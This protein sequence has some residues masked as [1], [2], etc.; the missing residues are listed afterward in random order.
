SGGSSTP[1]GG[2]ASGQTFQAGAQGSRGYAVPLEWWEND[3]VLRDMQDGFLAMSVVALSIA[4]GAIA[5]EAAAALA[6]EVR[7]TMYLMSRLGPA[8]G[9]G[10]GGGAAARGAIQ[11]GKTLNATVGKQAANV[12]REVLKGRQPLSALTEAQRQGAAAFYRD[13]ATRVG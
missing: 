11:V 1:G 13:V 7:T 2:T 8:S 12:V 3:A 9:V 6:V 10:L 4:S 5:V